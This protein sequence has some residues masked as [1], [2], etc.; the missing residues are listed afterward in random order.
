M[1]LPRK[2]SPPPPVKFI[3]AVGLTPGTHKCAILDLNLFHIIVCV[4]VQWTFEKLCQATLRSTFER[5]MP[6]PGTEKS[7]MPLQLSVL[8][9]DWNRADDGSTLVMTQCSR[10]IDAYYVSVVL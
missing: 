4:H 6:V 10:P 2:K 3:L 8:R 5:Q 9:P 1:F 7:K